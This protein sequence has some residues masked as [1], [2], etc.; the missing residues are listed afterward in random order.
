MMTLRD[1][2]PGMC[3]RFTSKTAPD[4]RLMYTLLDE[5]AKVNTL[6]EP[7][8]TG[9]DS[10]YWEDPRSVVRS[11]F[12]RQH[13]DEPVQLL[14][15][16]SKA[17]EGRAIKEYQ[18][19]WASSIR[20]LQ[21]YL[22]GEWNEASAKS[23]AAAL[24]RLEVAP[25]S[26][27]SAHGPSSEGGWAV[28]RSLPETA[29]FVANPPRVLSC[30]DPFKDLSDVVSDLERLRVD[31]RTG[32]Q[33]LA[34]FEQGQQ[35]ESIVWNGVGFVCTNADCGMSSAQVEHARFLWAATLKLKIARQK[36]ADAERE[37]MQVVCDDQYEI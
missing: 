15:H 19:V 1:V 2:K 14:M 10:H 21:W 28:V 8:P 5:E 23:V 20:P 34:R 36:A 26:Y 18:A 30:V 16:Y 27:R 37:Q 33:C 11:R 25:K 4:R 32:A 7:L 31:G 29:P 35:T 17:P 3:W 24:N 6:R 12:Y 9:W 22:G 13:A